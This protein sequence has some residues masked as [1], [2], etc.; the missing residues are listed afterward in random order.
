[1]IVDEKTARY[2]SEHKGRTYY[3]CALGCKQAFEKDP[4]KYVKM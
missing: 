1:M 4:D 2:K 3:F